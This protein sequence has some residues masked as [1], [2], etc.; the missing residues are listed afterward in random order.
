MAG[1][2]REGY[3]LA[4]RSAARLSS[5]AVTL[6]GILASASGCRSEVTGWIIAERGSPEM[7][8]NDGGSNDGGSNDGGSTDGGCSFCPGV[9]IWSAPMATPQF[10]V[11]DMTEH[12]DACPNGEA[13]IGFQGSIDDVGVVLVSSIQGFC[14][15]LAIAS[16]TAT[17]VS[18]T[19]N[20]V[21]PERGTATA[22]SWTQ[23][24]PRDQVVVGFYGRSGLGLDQVGFDCARVRVSRG[25]AG[26]Y[27]LSVD[28]TISELSPPNGGNGG[29]AFRAP[30]AAGQ[31]AR[32]ANVNIEQ[33]VHA[34]GLTCSTPS[35]AASDAATP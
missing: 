26:D 27:A 5:F 3:R 35:V 16:P 6:A 24:C 30:C 28:T 12:D 15:K 10:G 19:A 9:I 8:G 14:G 32:V 18:V 7:P 20:S 31:V 23:M 34:F 21:L 33:W 2:R 22:A 11:P 1:P 4:V 25:D 29:S 13:L 17:D